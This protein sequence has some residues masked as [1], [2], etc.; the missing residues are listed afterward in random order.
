MQGSA[1]ARHCSNVMGY[2]DG[3]AECSEEDDEEEDELCPHPLLALRVALCAHCTLIIHSCAHPPCVLMCSCA[4]PLKCSSSLFF[5]G[6][7]RFVCSSPAGLAC[8]LACGLVSKHLCHNCTTI[9]NLIC[10]TIWLAAGS[11]GA[12]G[13]TGCHG[14]QGGWARSKQATARLTTIVKQSH[15]QS[16]HNSWPQWFLK[17]FWFYRD[18]L[19]PPLTIARLRKVCSA[20]RRHEVCS[21]TR[22][23]V[24]AMVQL[25]R[26]VMKTIIRTIS[27]ASGSACVYT[28]CILDAY[29]FRAF[30]RAAFNVL[31]IL[32]F[33]YLFRW[34]WASF[35]SV[36]TVYTMYT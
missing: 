25:A 30:F 22:S 5:D 29:F 35:T 1:P 8:G 31:K 28:G 15:T 20:M 21:A 27:P 36:Y 2:V 7:I 19:H 18:S 26:D 6:L 33:S 24:T 34:F 17:R 13:A 11:T 23:P 3:G 4:H 14:H 16:A 32:L 12:T 10:V 9:C